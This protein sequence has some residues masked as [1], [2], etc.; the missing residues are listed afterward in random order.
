MTRDV[1][2]TDPDSIQ[3]FYEFEGKVGAITAIIFRLKMEGIKL[4]SFW[5]K[6]PEKILFGSEN[7]FLELLKNYC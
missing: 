6:S 5:H 7:N 1:K 2:F 4:Y 3:L